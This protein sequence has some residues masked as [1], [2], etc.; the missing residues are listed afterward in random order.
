MGYV[1][2]FVYNMYVKLL[3]ARVLGSKLQL[4]IKI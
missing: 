2:Y 3:V 1:G 4:Q